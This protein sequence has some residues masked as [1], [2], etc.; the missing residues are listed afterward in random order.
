MSNTV[1]ITIKYNIWVPS[2][3]LDGNNFKH[4]SLSW[5]LQELIPRGVACT[6]TDFKSPTNRSA[7]PNYVAQS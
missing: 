6:N 1:Q 3:Q 4:G 2:W 5:K 7:G